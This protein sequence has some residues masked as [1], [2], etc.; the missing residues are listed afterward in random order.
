MQA[1]QSS[2]YTEGSS[3][4]FEA[5][6]L[7]VLVCMSGGQFYAIENK[8]S[9]QD[10][11]LEGGTVRKASIFCPSHGAC[12]S[13]KDGSSHSPLAMGRNIRTFPVDVSDGILTVDLSDD[14][15]QSE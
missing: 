15:T 14:P 8:C 4:V 5:A 12:F 10:S 13:L 2:D 9:H 7:S 11:P 6:G 1:G 3:K